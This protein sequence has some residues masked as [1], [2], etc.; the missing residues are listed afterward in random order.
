WVPAIFTRNYEIY[1]SNYCWIHNTYHINISEPNMKKANQKR[2]VLRYYQ[3]VPFILLI[4]SLFYILPRLFWRSLSRHSGIDVK[5][6]IDAAQSLKTVKRFHKQ[7][8]IMQYLIS[9]ISQY[10]SNPRKKQKP[11]HTKWNTYVYGLICCMFGMNYFNAYL[12]LLYL[13]VKLLYIANSLFQ[14]CAIYILLESSFHRK[15]F[16][17][18]NIFY[19]ILKQNHMSKYFPKISMCDF[20]IIEPNSDEGH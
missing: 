12:L 19:G 17:I 9:L 14:I 4:Q 15:S 16:N 6:L 5:N 2:Y 20:R 11:Q 1:V 18:H 8:V 10:V 7:K 13:F 3:F